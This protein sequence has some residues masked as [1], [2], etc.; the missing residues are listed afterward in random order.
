MNEIIEKKCYWISFII[1]IVF[2]L[3]PD[4]YKKNGTDN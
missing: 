2:E 1:L 3:E 4:G